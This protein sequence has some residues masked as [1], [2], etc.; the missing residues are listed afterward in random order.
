MFIDRPE[1]V[2]VQYKL[3]ST[4]ME[5]MP[6]SKTEPLELFRID[7]N[8]K[9]LLPE[10]IPNAVAPSFDKLDLNSI[11]EEIERYKVFLDYNQYIWWQTLFAEPS[12][13]MPLDHVEWYLNDI[14]AMAAPQQ[15]EPTIVS[16][17]ALRH[18]I[19]KE[20]TMPPVSPLLFQNI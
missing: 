1:H 12:S 3:W 16:D 19:Q 13:P 7:S 15:E 11:R 9:Q 4:D 5:W 18:L 2:A 17:T 20:R 14:Q 10:G 8:G 6:D